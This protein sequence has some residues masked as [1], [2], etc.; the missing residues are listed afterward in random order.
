MSEDRWVRERDA[1]DELAAELDPTRLPPRPIDELEEAL[2][3]QLGDLRGKSVLELG[4]GSGDLTFH[5]VSAGAAVTA[6]DISPGMVEVARR[7]LAVYA[8]EHEVEWIVGPAEEASKQCEPFDIVVGKWIL[9]HTDTEALAP[10][11]A[12]LLHEGGRGVFIENSGFNPILRFA[13]RHVAGRAG[14]PR[15]GT[16]DEHPL[17]DADYDA[18]RR[19]FAAV[20]LS[21]PNFD[22]FRL[23]DRQVFRFRHRRISRVLHALDRL[24]YRVRPLR[25]YSFRV[26]VEVVR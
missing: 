14:I 22:F 6:L 25:R 13:R 3:A 26:I 9:H 15:L 21:F 19:H 24:L 20:E 11:L 17:L 2:L 5:L 7:R 8:P 12:R 23:F 16:E 10:E 4:C 1:H 18:F